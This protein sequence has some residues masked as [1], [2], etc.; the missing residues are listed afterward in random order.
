MLHRCWL[1][2][3]AESIVQHHLVSQQ[4]ALFEVNLEEAQL[5]PLL[6]QRLALNCLENAA[7]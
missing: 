2:V 4:A 1:V 7:V 3:D 5:S 6:K